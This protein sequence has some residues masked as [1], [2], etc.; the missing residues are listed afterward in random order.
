MAIECLAS[1][2]GK[3]VYC[4]VLSSLSSVDDP[5]TPDGSGKR[6]EMAWDLQASGRP[7]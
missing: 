7:S 1:E 3:P 5:D 4:N 6:V 2:L